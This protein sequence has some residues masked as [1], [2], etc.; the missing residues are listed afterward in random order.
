[1]HTVLEEL[2]AQTMIPQNLSD[3]M[4]K[5]MAFPSAAFIKSRVAF[6]LLAKAEMT[7]S[8]MEE[9]K[10]LVGEIYRLA[11][12]ELVGA[13]ISK[14]LNSSLPLS[15]VD[16]Y[17]AA[18]KANALKPVDANW[19]PEAELVVYDEKAKA[20]RKI[21][22]E[23]LTAKDSAKRPRFTPPSERFGK[24]QH[25]FKGGP[26]YQP[27]SFGGAPPPPPPGRPGGRY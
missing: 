21:H 17:A 12:N 8:D 19:K 14:E 26:R 20:A 10:R 11:N 18:A 25:D 24:Q 4:T 2:K 3:Q 23:N 1:M 7:E 13:E 15:F 16:V 5:K 9:A 22:K 27:P 6:N